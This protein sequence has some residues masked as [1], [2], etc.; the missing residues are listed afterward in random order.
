MAEPTPSPTVITN[1]IPDYNLPLY[2]TTA[3]VSTWKNTVNNQENWDKYYPYQLML[4]RPLH[5]G[6]YVP[7]P[8]WK[9]TLPIPPESMSITLMSADRVEATLNG[10]TEKLGGA[11]FREISLSGTTGINVGKGSVGGSSPGGGSLGQAFTNQARSI[12]AGVASAF[13]Q[14]VRIKNEISI[15]TSQGEESRTSGFLL[16]HGLRTFLEGYI[17]IKQ[18][19]S[20]PKQDDFGLETHKSLIGL[21]P[22]E[23]RLAF[24]NWK[25]DSIYLC[26]LKNFDMKRAANTPME[27]MYSLNL[28]AFRR[29]ALNAQAGSVALIERRDGVSP[30]IVNDVLNRLQSARQVIIASKRLLNTALLGPLAIVSEVSRQVTGAVKDTAGVVRDVVE[31]PA[32]FARGMLN[33]F[34]A[35][36]AAVNDASNTV[37]QNYKQLYENLD[38]DFRLTFGISLADRTSSNPSIVSGTG[39]EVSTNKNLPQTQIS[40]S[41]DRL[42]KTTD[43]SAPDPR[44]YTAF[45]AIPADKASASQ[46]LRAQLEAEIAAGRA[47]TASDVTA[48]RIQ[49]QAASDEFA[50][51]IGAWSEDYQELFDLATPTTTQRAPTQEEFDALAAMNEIISSTD[52]FA[53]YLLE[54]DTQ[55]ETVPDSLEYVAGLAEQSGIAFTIPSSKFAVPFPYN[56]TLEGLALT[57]LGDANRWH[58]IATL[59]GLRAPYVDELGVS[60]Q[61]LSNGDQNTIAVSDITNL[62]LKQTIYLRSDSQ[63]RESR[64]VINIQEITPTNYIITLDG[65]KDLDRFL[66]ADNATMECF[67]PGTVNSRKTIYIPSQADPDDPTDVEA[68]PGVD[69]FDPLLRVAGVDWLL[70]DNLG[71]IVT[72][73]GDNPL[74]YGLRN[75]VQTLQIGFTTPRAS[76]KQHPGFGIGVKPGTSTSDLDAK[77]IVASVNEFVDADPTFSALK[78]ADISILGNKY[79]LNVEVGIAG[80]T[81]SVPVSFPLNY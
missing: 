63:N 7:I 13:G 57:Y 81:K 41:D 78:R 65:D 31:M 69:V 58:E 48:F 3:F 23:I 39:V 52:K 47:I 24:C 56:G 8:L 30:N 10:Y 44:D 28:R 9:Y 22:K 18:S 33:E 61:M 16:F 80:T 51:Q 14:P 55:S 79:R 5:D 12:S 2:S 36:R 72:E 34:K 27:Y 64:H 4:V 25:D 35:A 37:N 26:T 32:S 45:G 68:I 53:Y 6:S 40:D 59:N 15:T 42:S 67:L 54:Q 49:L 11:P 21:D 62:F 75:I 43:N 1:N 71:L 19:G 17:A 77:S 66:T 46:G 74:S 60:L 20:I 38:D 76:L 70:D 29:I 73:S 50:E